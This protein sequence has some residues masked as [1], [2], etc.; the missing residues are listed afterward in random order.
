MKILDKNKFIKGN[1]MPIFI[2]KVLP[3]GLLGL[4]AAGMFAAFMSTH[5]SYLLSWSS[6][7]TQ[8]IV[9]PKKRINSRIKLAF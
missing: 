4:I 8:D 3:S 6:V 1:T 5:D 9:A 7:I 2:A